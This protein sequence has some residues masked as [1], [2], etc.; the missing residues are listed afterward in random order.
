MI[1]KLG[2]G[3]ILV[4]V[5]AIIGFC[6]G[7]K[8]DFAK[9]DASP[10]TL[11]LPRS[12]LDAYIEHSERKV[13]DLKPDNRARIIWHD[14]LHTK[15]E[16]ALVYLHGF[17]A[18]QEEGDPIHESFA[19]RYGMNLYLSR[20]EGHGR[21]DSNSFVNLTPLDYLD[22]AREAIAIGRLL[23]DK[24]IVMSC[25]TG[26]TLS[27]PLA[28][29]DE[30]IVAQIMYS[31]NI[32]INDPAASFLNDP[33]GK[34]ILKQVMG[35][36]YNHIEYDSLGD[37]YWNPVYHTN[38]LIA[39]Q[40]LIEQVMTVDNFHKT[41]KPLFMGYYYKSDK[42]QDDVVSIPAMLDFFEQIS[43][44]DHLKRKIAFPDARSHVISSHVQSKDY[45]SVLEETLAFAEEVLML[46]P[47]DD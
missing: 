9:I 32:A 5:I 33:W 35:S 2:I 40:D 43:T 3:F 36:D 47:I 6:L 15:T 10:M 4:V 13:V 29:E 25:S 17:S 1:K 22:T 34:Q 31:P 41:D 24:I 30:D 38:G 14:S 44:P 8:V 12:E 16:Y 37:A 26:S 18:S 42:E 45:L 28:A 21:V 46:I 19:D 20:L 23:G 27:I 11:D 39:L 7:P